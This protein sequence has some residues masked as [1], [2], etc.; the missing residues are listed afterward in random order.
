MPDWFGFVINA[1]LLLNKV[2]TGGLWPGSTPCDYEQI[3]PG[4]FGLCVM[5]TDAQQRTLSLSSLHFC[6]IRT[7]KDWLATSVFPHLQKNVRH[8]GTKKG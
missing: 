1:L 2:P 5:G 8:T 7:P 4:D 3:P 6:V